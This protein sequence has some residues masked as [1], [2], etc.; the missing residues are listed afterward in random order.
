MR[1]PL[2]VVLSLCLLLGVL[3]QA[4]EGLE[5]GG[6]MGSKQK[7]SRSRKAKNN[8]FFTF[9]VEPCTYCLSDPVTVRGS[10]ACKCSEG[11]P[12]GVGIFI[13][14]HLQPAGGSQVQACS[15]PFSSNLGT[16]SV[17]GD[18]S[19]PVSRGLRLS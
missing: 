17:S 5:E 7:T 19:A 6:A 8:H 1:M 12:F 3:G 18:S 10:S 9:G 16:S 11:E 15:T 13:S 4:F 2:L 14:V